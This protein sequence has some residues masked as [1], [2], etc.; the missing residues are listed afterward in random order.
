MP[1]WIEGTMKV[2]GTKDNLMQFLNNVIDG[3]VAHK[4]DNNVEYGLPEVEYSLPESAYVSDSRRAFVRESCYCYIYDNK[5]IQIIT[6]PIQQAW[7]FG[8]NDLVAERWITLAKKYSV[9]IR[10]QGFECGMEFY[11]DYAIEDGK[12]T[13][14]NIIQYDNWDWECPMPRLGG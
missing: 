9:D 6:I 4:L 7:S 2:R 12:V 3:V 11:Q 8:V 14:N 10:L 1:N 5:D 13:I